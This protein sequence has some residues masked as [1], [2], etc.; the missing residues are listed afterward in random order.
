MTK[1]VPAYEGVVIPG[2]VIRRNIAGPDITDYLT[3][4][5]ARERG[6]EFI[7]QVERE[8]VCDIKEKLCYVALHFDDEMKSGP[9]NPKIEKV[10]SELN[11]SLS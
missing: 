8:T 11:A 4:L 6:L 10:P 9:T 5:L 7:T 1:L 3:M 2:A